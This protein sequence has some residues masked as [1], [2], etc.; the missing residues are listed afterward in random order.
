MNDREKE[1]RDAILD[2]IRELRSLIDAYARIT[3]DDFYE[4]LPRLI[5][6]KSFL[7]CIEDGLY[8]D[9]PIDA[10]W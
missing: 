7:G 6:F 2:G 1:A 5:E 9:D 4:I 10:K 8:R 3:N